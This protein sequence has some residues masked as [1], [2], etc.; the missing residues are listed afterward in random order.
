MAKS[1]GQKCLHRATCVCCTSS[2]TRDCWLLLWNLWMGSYQCFKGFLTLLFFRG[3]LNVVMSLTN[4]TVLIV[5]SQKY[6]WIRPN[7]SSWTDKSSV[8]FLRC[9]QHHPGYLEIQ[10]WRSQIESNQTCTSYLNFYMFFNNVNLFFSP[11]Y[12]IFVSLSPFSSF[13]NSRFLLWY[14]YIHI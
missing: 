9:Q 12:H 2:K 6:T 13:L 4:E 1:T 8:V 10:E 7:T 3:K 11:S 5:P 14:I